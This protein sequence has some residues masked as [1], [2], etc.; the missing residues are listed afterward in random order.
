MIGTQFANAFACGTESFFASRFIGQSV[1]LFGALRIGLFSAIAGIIA[2]Y[3]VSLLNS[4]QAYILRA[5]AGFFSAGGVLIVLC[6]L[7]KVPEAKLLWN[8][9]QTFLTSSRRRVLVHE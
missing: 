7:F 1:Y 6:Y 9:I 4:P 2:M 3:L 5:S 8:R